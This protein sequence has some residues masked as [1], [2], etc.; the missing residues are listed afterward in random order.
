MD[1]VYQTHGTTFR[2]LEMSADVVPIPVQKI[3]EF[4]LGPVPTTWAF[5]GADAVA[6]IVVKPHARASAD[7]RAPNKA[8]EYLAFDARGMEWWSAANPR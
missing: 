7:Y 2:A 1:R 6:R 3:V 4:H 8:N 5:W